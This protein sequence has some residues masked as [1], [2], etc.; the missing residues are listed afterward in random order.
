MVLV[1]DFVIRPISAA[2]AEMKTLMT[3]RYA[4]CATLV[5]VV[6]MVREVLLL[7]ATTG[8]V[9]A[10]IRAV[11]ERERVT[12]VLASAITER[13]LARAVLPTGLV[14]AERKT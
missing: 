3:A 14:K 7:M 12:A 11:I 9:R 6:I 4:I 13:E 2:F 8:A 1:D 10:L 5:E